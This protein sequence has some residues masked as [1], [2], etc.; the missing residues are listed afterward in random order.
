VNVAN[1]NAE[2][3]ELVKNAE[4][5]SEED[6]SA[7][8]K[9]IK[10]G[11]LNGLD[12]I[13]GQ[14]FVILENSV[15]NDRTSIGVHEPG[16]AVFEKILDTK[17]GD[18]RALESAITEY[19]SKTDPDM[20]NVIRLKM[21]SGATQNIQSEE[22]VIEFL[23]QVDQ[24]NIDFKQKKNRKLAS[25]FG[26]MTNGITKVK[27]FEVDF[28]GETD[29]VSF[30]VGLAKKI[31]TGTLTKQDIADA[32]SS[33]ALA[34][35]VLATISSIVKQ[36][37]KKK[38]VKTSKEQDDRNV[39]YRDIFNKRFTVVDPDDSEKRIPISQQEYLNYMLVDGKKFDNKTK[40]GGVLTPEGA[41]LFED[42]SRDWIDQVMQ[43]SSFDAELAMT[44]ITGPFLNHLLAMN[45]EIQMTAKNPIAAYMGNYAPFKVGDARKQMAKGASPSNSLEI[46]AQVEGRKQFDPVAAEEVNIPEE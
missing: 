9:S 5:L 35:T 28:K 17:D 7:Q 39:K 30:L 6:K 38:K 45:P 24:G 18:F 41:Q 14:Q 2:A 16:H 19:L 21:S 1:T 23:E 20:L 42:V 25:L 12:N 34:P 10:D 46:D 43:L 4:N 37:P 44:T 40:K 3:I 15:K 22:F 31:S 13:N 26:F 29:A 36:G 32:R 33:E 11:T 8:I 27:G